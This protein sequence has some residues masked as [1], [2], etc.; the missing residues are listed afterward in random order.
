[1][2]SYF[3]FIF[4][5]VFPFLNIMEDWNIDKGQCMPARK[6]FLKIENYLKEPFF[7]H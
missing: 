3:L 6:L 4:I 1:M 2:M 5:I 7:S